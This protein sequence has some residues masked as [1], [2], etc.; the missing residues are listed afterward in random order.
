M[1]G[2]LALCRRNRNAN[3]SFAGDPLVMASAMSLAAGVMIFVSFAELFT[4]SQHQ[5]EDDGFE[6][7]LLYASISLFCG[8]LF[9]ALTDGLVHCCGGH[10]GHNHGVVNNDDLLLPSDE[11]GFANGSEGDNFAARMKQSPLYDPSSQG[12]GIVSSPSRLHQ[13]KSMG[14]LTSI[15][16][17]LHN[18]PEGLGV[19][20]ATLDEPSVGATL[21]VAVA[22]HNIPLGL[23]ISMS[24]WATERNHWKPLLVTFLVGAAQPLGGLVGYYLLEEIFTGTA[25]SILYG[26]VAGMMIYIAV[27]ELIPLASAYDKEKKYCTPAFFLGMLL[28]C[29]CML[30]TD[31]SDHH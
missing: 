30:A 3:N 11:S 9:T 31:G 28:V 12:D 27:K 13:L 8:S 6:N 23:S 17:A 10:H 26:A 22:L 20:V 18:L 19:F 14:V 16:L 5:F 29:A 7:P 24:L 1:L 15:S 21:A 2:N 4:E 25:L